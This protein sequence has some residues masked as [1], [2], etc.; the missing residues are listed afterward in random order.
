VT[1]GRELD[2]L[3]AERVM[4]TP[5]EWRTIR[6][7]RGDRREPRGPLPA[8]STDPVAALDVLNALGGIAYITRMSSEDWRVTLGG[9]TWWG[10]TLPLA[11][12]RAALESANIAP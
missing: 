7:M 4:G 9:E 1:D 8:Y 12:C 6:S 2:A 3:V 10:E 5:V 11:I